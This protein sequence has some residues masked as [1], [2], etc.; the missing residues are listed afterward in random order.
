MKNSLVTVVRPL[1]QPSDAWIKIFHILLS[2]PTHRLNSAVV[3][4]VGFDMKTPSSNP[5]EHL[6]F[7]VNIY[8][9]EF[10]RSFENAM[11]QSF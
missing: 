6:Y 10:A 11:Q 9:S 3:K 8:K 7:L 2:L 5:H 1:T 4:S